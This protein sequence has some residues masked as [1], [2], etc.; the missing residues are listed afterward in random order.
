MNLSI[1]Q[2]FKSKQTK[3]IESR[4]DHFTQL[5]EQIQSDKNKVM[6]DPVAYAKI[7]SMEKDYMRFIEELKKCL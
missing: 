6:R 5:I 4:I 7:W 3:K 2:L 1:K